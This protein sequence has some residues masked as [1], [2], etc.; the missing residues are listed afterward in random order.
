[1]DWKIA[2]DTYTCTRFN[3]CKCVTGKWSGE[4]PRCEAILCPPLEPS[5]AKLQLLEHNNTVG[6]R[7]VFACMWGHVLTGP[8]S[9]RCEGDG[10]W[11]GTMP[12]CKGEFD[13][14]V[15]LTLTVP[16]LTLL[17]NAVGCYII[18]DGRD[19]NCQ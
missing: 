2:R 1:M 17:S 16:L 10:V 7:A 11:N 13:C 9:I 6:G 3:Y 5:N 14:T 4:I 19:Y 15:I 18:H 8:L 12:T